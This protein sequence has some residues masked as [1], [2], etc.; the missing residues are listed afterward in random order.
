MN[1]IFTLYDI[2]FKR[3]Y[4]LY[5]SMLFAF[6]AFNVGVVVAG[7]INVV[8]KVS[9]RL[10]TNKSIQI[11]QKASSARIIREDVMGDIFTIMCMAFIVAIVICLLYAFVIWYRDFLGKSKTAYTLFML[12][13]NKFDMYIAKL[14]TIV[15]LI[16]GVIIAQFLSWIIS[17]FIVTSLTSVTLSQ[18]IYIL[19][20]RLSLSLLGFMQFDGISFI[21]INIIGTIISV[22]IIFTGIIIQKSFKKIGILLGIG[23]IVIFCM[24]N[25][26][27]IAYKSFSG[28][29]LMYQ[30]AYYLMT[31]LVSMGISYKLLNKKIYL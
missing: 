5:F 25:L 17:A 24:I 2:E 30:T 4:K 18:I 15:F 8:F 12:P 31:A 6:I 13:N 21:M 27:V 9:A 26:Y 29:L 1:K 19:Q 22:I 11:L 3:I 23:Y 16:Y 14:I 7:L 20:G 28:Q 10:E